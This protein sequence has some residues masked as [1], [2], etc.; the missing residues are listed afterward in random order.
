MS[1]TRL[2]LAACSLALVQP[3]AANDDAQLLYNASF[4]DPNPSNMDLPDGW[5]VFNTARYRYD[6][7]GIS[8]AAP[9]RT[10]TACIEFPS[11]TDFSGFTT[12]VFNPSTLTFFNPDYVWQGGDVTITGWYYIPADSPL[13]GANSGIKLEFRRDNSSIATAFEVL[14]ITGDTDDQW[15]EFSFTVTDQQIMDAAGDF[16]PFATSVTVLPLRFGDVTSTGTIFWDDL[17]LTQ[18]AMPD[19]PADVNGDGM[20][21]PADFTAWLGCFNDPNSQA[22]C[23]RADVNNS[24]GIEPADFTAWLAA[25]QAGCN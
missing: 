21:T 12:D 24:G 7:D 15:V 4:E 19:C 14:N 10:G 18:G 20:A 6:G 8:P 5:G 2:I 17:C 16:P 23:D 22:F 9:Y 3:A 11:G 13:D 25:F 1:P